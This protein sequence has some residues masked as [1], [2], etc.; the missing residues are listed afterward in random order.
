[1]RTIFLPLGITIFIA[2][3]SASNAEGIN[4]WRL[5]TAYVEVSKQAIHA[6]SVR[7]LDPPT[8]EFLK[9]LNKVGTVDQSE[10]QILSVLQ[11]TPLLNPSNEPF[12]SIG[13]HYG[14]QL[15]DNLWILIYRDKSNRYE[16]AKAIE[17]N[18]L[19]FQK[20]DRKYYKS[21]IFPKVEDLIIKSLE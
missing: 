7:L 4:L 17:I 6:P 12:A 10:K 19:I 14:L 2:F 15:G 3:L 8:V 13:M 18:G 20:E 1:M 9:R 5:D 21:S 16:I 11:N